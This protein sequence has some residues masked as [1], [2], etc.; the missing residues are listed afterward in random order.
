MAVF[1]IIYPLFRFCYLL[2][3]N[4]FFGVEVF[5]LPDNKIITSYNYMD[6]F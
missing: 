3:G 2:A 1:G 4:D 6:F 5:Y